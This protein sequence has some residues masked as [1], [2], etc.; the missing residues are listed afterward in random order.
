MRIAG[1]PITC[2]WKPWHRVLYSDQFAP[3]FT[4]DFVFPHLLEAVLT[5]F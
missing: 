5:S 3:Y 1:S 2:Y 4:H